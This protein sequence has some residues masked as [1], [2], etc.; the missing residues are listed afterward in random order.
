MKLI[1]FALLLLPLLNNIAVVKGSTS[2][3]DNTEA[4]PEDALIGGIEE[5]VKVASEI[6]EE[7]DLD[8]SPL[9]EALT[10]GKSFVE[11]L[12]P[13]LLTNQE[14]VQKSVITKALEIDEEFDI[15]SLPENA[16]DYMMRLIE[17]L[18]TKLAEVQEELDLALLASKL[19]EGKNHMSN[20]VLEFEKLLKQ[21]AET[22]LSNVVA[23]QMYEKQN[24]GSEK[25]KGALRGKNLCMKWVPCD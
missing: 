9:E 2:A 19:E 10:K 17:E 3:L 4:A 25:I 13:L 7:L 21:S 18:K 23:K 14:I 20:V 22:S 12:V 6:G 16:Q 11:S 24:Q 8:L 1:L 5:L 15:S